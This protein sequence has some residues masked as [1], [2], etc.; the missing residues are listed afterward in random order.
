[1]A[2]TAQDWPKIRQ[3]V[4]EVHDLDRRVETTTRLL[5]AAGLRLISVEQPPTLK[6]TNI[7]TI[8]A[9]RNR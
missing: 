4:V 5:M 7:F 9:T 2:S 8:F 6:D 3:V 1:M